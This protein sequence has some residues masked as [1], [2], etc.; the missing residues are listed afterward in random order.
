[1]KVTFVLPG[2][3]PLSPIGGFRVVYEYANH[4]VLRG[5]RVAVVHKR[6]PQGTQGS[7]LR[8]WMRRE[9]ASLHDR[10]RRPTVRWQH[11]DRRV[12]M[13]AVPELTERFIPDGDAVF[14]T[15]WETASLILGYPRRKGAKFYLVQ[16]FYPWFAP[17]K[18]LEETWAWPLNKVCVSRWLRQMVCA[19][20]SVG[21]GVVAIPNGTDCDRF[22]LK[23]EISARPRQVAMMYSRSPYKTAG[24]GLAALREVVSA[25]P[26]VRAVCF[27]PYRSPSDSMPEWLGQFWGIP[28]A[29]L[30]DLYNS[31]SVF[32]CSSAAEGFALPGAEA[33]A[34]GCA[35]ASTDCGGNRDYAEHGVTALLSPPGEPQALA[36]NLLRLLADDD[37]R[38]K[39]A[40]EGHKRIQAFT[41]ERSTGL[42]EKYMTECVGHAK[43]ASGGR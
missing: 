27:G 24:D 29:E 6:P 36:K 14:A 30:V 23:N 33:M 17:R 25:H 19:S 2:N 39:I 10:F 8:G 9:R 34:C 16:D 43:G 32:L 21:G 42:L 7:G 31:S 22:I 38:T 15:H 40:I 28:E 4:L 41:W 1:M 5:H 37:L 18:V 12:R 26:D 13:L 35:V 3:V 11:I 20:P